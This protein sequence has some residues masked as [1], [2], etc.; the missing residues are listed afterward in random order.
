MERYSRP[1]GAS[2]AEIFQA[3]L[4][5][6]KPGCAKL[7]RHRFPSNTDF[8]YVRRVDESSGL[9]EAFKALTPYKGLWGTF[10]FQKLEHVVSPRC[11]EVGRLPLHDEYLGN[12]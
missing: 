5:D 7:W 2:N 10:T 3:L 1:D 4:R 8:K 9:R 6:Q 11:Y 12:L